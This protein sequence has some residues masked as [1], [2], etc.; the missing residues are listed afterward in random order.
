MWTLAVAPL[1]LA[2]EVDQLRMNC[3]RA[4]RD[5]RE[6]V[7][8]SAVSQKFFNLCGRAV[9]RIQSGLYR[10]PFLLIDFDEHVL[11]AS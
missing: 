10:T 9:T 11:I 8:G 7:N 3:Q 5:Q 2:G 1:D 4:P 6:A